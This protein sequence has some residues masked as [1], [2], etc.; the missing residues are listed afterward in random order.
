MAI[1][2][3]KVLVG[4]PNQSNTV[5]AVNI[6]PIGTTLPTD[7][8]TALNGAFEKCGYVSEDGVSLSQN[9]NTVDIKDWSR[10]T[11]RTLLNEFTGQ[12]SL[13]FIQTGY[14]ELCAIFGAEN[15]IK[16]AATASAGEKLAVKI[17]AHLPSPKCFVFNMKDGDAKVRIVVPNAQ[18]V[19]D[20]DLVFVAN[21]PI[22]W[23]CK[24]TCNADADGESIYIY[25]DDGTPTTT[26]TTGA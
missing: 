2:A 7:A 25:T 8:T 9:Y 6:A 22:T 1:D 20:G 16:T 4:A 18:V 13:K 21:D 15:V 10:K 17:G 12:I 14:E 23:G 24:L 3:K 11:V 26:T 5:G 19:P